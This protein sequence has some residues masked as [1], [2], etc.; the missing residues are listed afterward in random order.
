MEKKEMLTSWENIT[1]S[2][3]VAIWLTG[4]KAEKF[5]ETEAAHINFEKINM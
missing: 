2:R 4:G 1:F 5:W 3:N